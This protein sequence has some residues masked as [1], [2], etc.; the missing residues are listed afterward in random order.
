MFKLLSQLLHKLFLNQLIFTLISFEIKFKS[1][2]KNSI[3][4]E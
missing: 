1:I 2:I 3:D 4:F